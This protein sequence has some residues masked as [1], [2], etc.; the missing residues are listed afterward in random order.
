M[1]V[2]GHRNELRLIRVGK[3]TL[4]YDLKLGLAGYRWIWFGL[5]VRWIVYVGM[6]RIGVFLYEMNFE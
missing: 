6:E 4:V 3:W 1:A 5:A 2:M